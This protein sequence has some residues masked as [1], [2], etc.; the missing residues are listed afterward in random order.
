MAY[1]SYT[2]H[3]FGV[4]QGLSVT[5]LTWAFFV[6]ATPI[7]DAGF[8]LAFPDSPSSRVRMFY[9]QIVVWVLA[10]VLVAYYMT[11]EPSVFEKTGILQLFYTILTT[12]WPLWLILA[13]S[14][15]GTYVSIKFDDDIVDV[16]GA[17]HKKQL[18]AR[19]RRQLVLS[20]SIFLVTVLMYVVLLH[21]THTTIALW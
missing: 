21:T 2:I 13:F 17:K 6:F 14:F 11:V 8:L 7:A 20:A 18:F 10:A 5:G 15:L 12:P 4:Q 9:T 3:N 1:T 16:A 19:K